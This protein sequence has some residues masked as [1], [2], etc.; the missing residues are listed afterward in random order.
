ML[1]CIDANA[2]ISDSRICGNCKDY[3]NC[4]GNIAFCPSASARRAINNAPTVECEPDKG[5]ISVT[6]R[7]PDDNGNYLVLN[8]G[9]IEIAPYDKEA[10][11][12]GFFPFG[13]EDKEIDE[14]GNTLIDWIE[15]SGVT[16]WMPLP[17]PP[18]EV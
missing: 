7:L 9:V 8:K 1:R 10:A 14:I 18:K 11:Q 12:E 17:E 15:I 16:H 4:D 13:Y 2:L 6:D 3:E 5:W